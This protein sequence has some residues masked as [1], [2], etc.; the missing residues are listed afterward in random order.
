MT[1]QAKM[2]LIKTLAYGATAEDV[3]SIGR[4]ELEDVQKFIKEHKDEIAAKK[5][6]LEGDGWIE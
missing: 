4:M 1:E 5:A 3:T 2:E 6:E